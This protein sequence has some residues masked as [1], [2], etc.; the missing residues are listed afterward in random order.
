MLA[1]YFNLYPYMVNGVPGCRGQGFAEYYQTEFLTYMDS[2]GFDTDEK[3]A[4]ASLSKMKDFYDYMTRDRLINPF[5]R[6]YTPATGPTFAK[7]TRMEPDDTPYFLFYIAENKDSLVYDIK[8]LGVAKDNFY[9]SQSN[10]ISSGP[11]VVDSIDRTNNILQW[12]R[13]SSNDIV[14][15]KNMKQIWPVVTGE[16]PV[17]LVKFL[18]K[19]REK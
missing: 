2:K 7:V 8:N 15:D 6:S 10:K 11:I 14:V 4:G 13:L 12:K 3:F 9:I 16:S 5:L 19:S 18:T 17:K 1:Y